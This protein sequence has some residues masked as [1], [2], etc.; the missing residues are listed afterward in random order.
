LGYAFLKDDMT[1]K[2][3]AII[4]H[5][6]RDLD[7]KL[8]LILAQTTKTNGRVDQLESW[9]DKVQGALIPVAVLSPVLTG[10]I[11]S[12]LSR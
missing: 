8:A 2:E 4:E 6:L 5:R 10:L 7:N 12:Y 1:A 9:K 11:I 3:T